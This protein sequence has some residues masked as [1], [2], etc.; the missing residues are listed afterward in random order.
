[1]RRPHV[2]SRLPSMNAIEKPGDTYR[3]GTT[4]ISSSSTNLRAPRTG[5]LAQRRRPHLLLITVTGCLL[6]VL[7]LAG[8]ASRD[9]L[10][11]IAVAFVFVLAIV[12]WLT[13]DLLAVTT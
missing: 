11:G 4:Q 7:V 3:S 5:L 1:M 13:R 6:V 10:L 2:A 8:S 12:G 9:S